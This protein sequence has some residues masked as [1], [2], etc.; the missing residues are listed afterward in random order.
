MASKMTGSGKTLINVVSAVGLLLITTVINFFLTPY[1]IA[2]IGPEANGFIALATNF[3]AYATIVTVAFNSMAGRYVTVNLHRH[4]LTAAREYYSTVFFVNLVI[5]GLVI[6]A[7]AGLVSGLDKI[8]SIPSQL[9]GDVKLLFGL[10]F[11][12]FCL[13]LV[14]EVWVILAYATDNLYRISIWRTIAVLVR[15]VALVALFR[16]LPT[17][18]AHV[19][20]AA[21]IGNLLLLIAIYFVTRNLVADFAPRLDAFNF[22]KI[23]KLVLSGIW[24]TLT[25]LGNILS[26]GLDLLMSNLFLSPVAMG[27]LAIPKTINT[28]ASSFL[29]T[30]TGALIPR[31]TIAYAKNRDKNMLDD[32]L[33]SMKF[34]GVMSSVMFSWL[35][36]FSGVFF[37]AWVPSQNQAELWIL[38]MLSFQ[39][40]L[41]S[42]NMDPLFAVF[43]ITNNLKINA[44]LRLAGG[45]LSVVLVYILLKTTNLGLFLIAGVSPIVGNLINLSF[46][47]LYV[48]RLLQVSANKF[49]QVIAKHLLSTTISVMVMLAVQ[50]I[51]NLTGW[52]GVLLSLL[53]TTMIGLGINYWLVFNQNDKNYIRQ[54]IAVLMKKK[55][56]KCKK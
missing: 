44:L 23:K 52:T 43:G 46:V 20:L 40:L 9:V 37:A 32:L 17:S 3:V 22:E 41:W 48:A 31:F 13:N 29:A 8:L 5:S 49:Y 33:M 36:V 18:V 45:G 28:I 1:I 19:G 6:I 2:N 55:G 7:S 25:T 35:C 34:N 38:G 56:E 10:V 39:S 51:L 14:T 42:G 47:P 15:L 4:K 27:V 30:V 12:N 53:L 11:V 26:D 16:F 24:N 21:L 50:S 54:T